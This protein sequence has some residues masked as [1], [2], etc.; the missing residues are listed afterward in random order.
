MRLIVVCHT[1]FNTRKLSLFF[2]AKTSQ[3]NGSCMENGDFNLLLHAIM[4]SCCA[5]MPTFDRLRIGHF[6]AKHN[7]ICNLPYMMTANNTY[8]ST[9]FPFKTSLCIKRMSLINKV[10]F[11]KGFSKIISHAPNNQSLR[12]HCTILSLIT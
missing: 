6:V 9:Y 3:T 11:S 8:L 10:N 5:D 4:H 1:H 12:Y 2:V 7:K